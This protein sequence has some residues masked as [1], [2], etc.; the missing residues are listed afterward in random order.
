MKTRTLLIL[1]SA[2]LFLLAGCVQTNQPNA[3]TEEARLCPDG[4]SVGRVGPNCTFAPC[5][6]CICPQGYTQEADTC[7]PACYYSTPKC[8]TPSILCN[9]TSGSSMSVVNASNQ[10]AF[11]LYSQYKSQDGNIFFSPYSIST[12]LAMTYE[13]ARGKTAE[14]MQVVFQKTT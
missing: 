4:S 11:E 13:G 10:F 9:T 12:A 7:N 14:E 6:N 5:P 1:L 2:A 8:L 3:C